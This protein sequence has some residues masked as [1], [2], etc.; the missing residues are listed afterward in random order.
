MPLFRQ[1]QKSSISPKKNKE[2]DKEKENTKL[3]AIFAQQAKEKVEC[4]GYMCYPCR[5]DSC[6]ESRRPKTDNLNLPQLYKP[7]FTKK[8]GKGVTV[9]N[10]HQTMI[11][12]E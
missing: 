2:I 9:K 5:D 8:E 3:E 4:K 11:Q 10:H 6:T 12:L 1:S 7:D